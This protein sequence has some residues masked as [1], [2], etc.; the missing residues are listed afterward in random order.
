MLAPALLT[1]NPLFLA[2]LAPRSMFLLAA[3]AR[4]PLLVY[5]LA[6]A[7]RLT[8]ASPS[9]F[10][11]GRTWGR[12]ATARM[13]GSLLPF[14]VATG[15]AEWLFRR[16]GPVALLVSPTGKTVALA[17]AA[18]VPTIRIALGVG[19]GVLGRLLVLYTVAHR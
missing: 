5:L 9:Y 19:A 16:L 18:E 14:R 17:S 10:S 8:A 6:G 4:T 2:T 1:K 15:F 11:M 3:A 7:L 13:R 12:Q